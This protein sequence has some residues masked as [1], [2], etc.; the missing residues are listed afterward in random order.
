MPRVIFE[1]SDREA[2]VRGAPARLER[3]IE[4]LVDNALS[5]SPAD[6][7]VLVCVESD[8]GKV[9]LAVCDDGPGIPEERRE[10]VF[11]RF[12][13]VRPEGEAFG[14]HSGLG[15][16]IAR[17]IVEAHDGTLTIRDRPDG[18]RGAYVVAE[19]PAG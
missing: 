19:F 5:F 2:R 13:S 1:A 11:E 4:N 18:R 7:A 6:A 3:A 8:G 15:L 14:A 9:R 10:A 12:H 17:T 16:A